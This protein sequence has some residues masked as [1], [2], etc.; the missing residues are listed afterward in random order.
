M[1]GSAPRR[2][3]PR[4]HVSRGFRRSERRNVSG[5][6]VDVSPPALSRGGDRPTVGGARKLPGA[7]LGGASWLL[8]ILNIGTSPTT[9]RRSGGSTAAGGPGSSAVGARHPARVP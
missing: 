3:R 1:P 6:T 4:Q 2:Q 7:H 9:T 8:D 5:E